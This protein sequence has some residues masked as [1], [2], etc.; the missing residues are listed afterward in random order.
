MMSRDEY[1]HPLAQ[2]ES[3]CAEVASHGPLARFIVVVEVAALILRWEIRMLDRDLPQHPFLVARQL[4]EEARSAV[5]TRYEVVVYG[6]QKT[7]G[8]ESGEMEAKHHQLFQALWVGYD[9]TQF[10]DRIQQYVKRIEVN[11]LAVDIKDAVCIDF[12]CGHGNFAHA[13]VR[14]GARSVLGIDFGEASIEYA[15]RVAQHLN[16]RRISFRCASVYDSGELDEAYDFAIQNGV[17]HHLDDEDRAY[18]EV[19]RVLRAGGAFGSTPT[20]PTRFKGISRML[21]REL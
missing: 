1:R 10:L 19:H 3:D 9:D 2:L 15:G 5:R 21:Q 20:A 4:I 13:L 18:R 17:F 16:E 12:G 7:V 11:N 8:L 6:E 14:S